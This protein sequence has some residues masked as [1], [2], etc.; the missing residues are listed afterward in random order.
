MPARSSKPWFHKRSGYWCTSEQ[1]RRIYLDRDYQVAAAKLR[2]RRAAKLRAEHG[3]RCEWLDVPFA[4]LADEFLDDIQARRA[5][6]TYDGYRYRLTRA[7]KILGAK[8]RVGE[9]R[10]IHLAKIEQKLTGKVGPTTVKDTIATVQCVFSWAVKHDLLIDNPLVGFEKP[11]GRSRTRI[12][13]PAEFQSLLRH[14]DAS[15]RRFL[16]ALR[17]TGC[18]PGEARQL[19]WQAVDLDQGLWILH[20]H[21]TVT[22]QRRPM[23]RIIPLDTTVWNLCRW[24][25]RNNPPAA[26]NVFLGR[27]GQPFGKDTVCRKMARLR[28]R[29]G[30]KLKGGE[31][32]VL[33]SAR[34]TFGTESSGRISDIELAN[35][36]GHTDIRTTQ[37]YVHLNT[38]RLRDALR[39]ATARDERRS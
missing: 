31:Q 36:M 25:R 20:H 15:F 23:P 34:H 10:K 39:R 9:L 16:I 32:L 38:D 6:A 17:R 7:L 37:R 27:N 33:Y 18:R 35:L 22:R 2:E 21:K 12:I 13:T 3:S 1:G 19:T 26:N 29:A 8:L 30:I 11:R 5:K 24:L 14:T 28:E 4:L